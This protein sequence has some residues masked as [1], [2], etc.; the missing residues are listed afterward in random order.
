MV[1]EIEKTSISFY[2]ILKAH[3]KLVYFKS[4]WV[5]Y[6]SSFII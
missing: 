2:F 5:G 1:A 6:L 3:Y 4:V